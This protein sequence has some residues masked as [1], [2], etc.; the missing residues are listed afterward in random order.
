MRFNG[1]TETTTCPL[2]LPVP[3]ISLNSTMICSCNVGF[4]HIQCSSPALCVVVPLWG[5]VYKLRVHAVISYK[6]SQPQ[7]ILPVPLKHLL[8]SRLTVIHK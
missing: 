1:H 5:G 6:V 4:L 3:T 2:L 8:L 7:P